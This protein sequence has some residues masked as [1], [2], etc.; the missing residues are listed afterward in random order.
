MKIAVNYAILSSTIVFMLTG[1]ASVKTPTTTPLKIE[2]TAQG[3]GK[4]YL[5]DGPMKGVSKETI[6]AIPEPVPKKEILSTGA[7]KPYTVNGKYYTPMLSLAPYRE[8]GVGS[9]YGMRYH[10]L[11]TSNGEIYD[12]LKLT[13][14]HPTLPL[15]SYVRVTNLNNQKSLIV[16]VN[17]RGPFLAGRLID[18]S[19]AAAFR[20]GYAEKGSAPLEVE[21]IIP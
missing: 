19:Y 15:P 5:N 4:Y 10:G 11:K 16:R 9:W 21:L 17:D 8:T 7:K 6:D 1:C 18:L 20:L 2:N 14:A 12:V 3:S 13:A